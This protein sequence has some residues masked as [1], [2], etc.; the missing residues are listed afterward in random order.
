MTLPASIVRTPALDRWLRFN[1]DGSLTVYTGKAELGQGITTAIAMI[2]A[3]ELDLPLER[4]RVQTADTE[5]TPNELITAGSMSV[6]QSGSA[7]RVASAAARE[8]L[9]E[10]AA[11]VL[12]VPENSLHLEDGVVTSPQTNEQTDYWSLLDGQGFDLDITEAPRLKDPH[13]YR[14]VGR[15]QHR[16]DIPAKVSGDVAFVHDMELPNLR[17]G[18]LV[19][20]P[21]AAAR[22]LDAPEQL[23]DFDGIVVRNG[24]FLGVVAA[25][26]AD[27]VA[28]AEALAQKA[29]WSSPALDPLPEAIPDYLRASVSQSLR[30]IDGTPVED[31]DAAPPPLP[32]AGQSVSASYYRPF[33]M[34]G[35]MGPSAA[36]AQFLNGVLTVFSHSQGVEILKRALMELLNLGA[37]QVHVIH[38]EGAGCYGHNGA[39]DVAFDAA[40]LAMAA[41]PDP[42]KVCW[43]RTEEHGWEPYGPATVVDMRAQL[44]PE[45]RIL[46]WQHEA[47][48]FSHN[49]RPR[50]AA[51][52][53]AARWLDPPVEPP[54]RTPALFA[55]VGIHR[56]M[57]P[58]Y[59]LP[60]TH[61]VKHFVADSPLRTSSL[62]SLGAF[63]NVFAI[64]S[65]MDELAHA[66][67]ADPIGFRLDHLED[68]RARAVLTA[69]AERAPV[70]PAADSAGRGVAIARYKNR[71]T[72][73]AVLV[74]LTVGDDAVVRLD[75]VVIVA[76]A[77]LVV[78][79]DGLVNQLEGGFIQAAS[80]TLKEEVRWDADGV[81]TLDWET[82]PI[83]TFPEIP[84]IET[85]LID[86]PLERSL[87]VGEASTGPTPAAIANAI[88]DAKGVRVR[89]LPFTPDRIRVAAAQ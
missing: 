85:H 65:F 9:L 42:V 21:V 72:W 26:A 22:L 43:T 10:R 54:P 56:N 77:G 6:E 68:P 24:S 84:V 66:A 46:A 11:R 3:E 12:R 78:D 30:V 71:Q 47:Y 8:A 4:I 79:P 19:K 31:A 45:G 57:E 44:S 60:A 48:S 58:L 81:T 38:E 67:G 35:S 74:D 80:W 51:N 61:L 16:V 53:L 25:T 5:L 75:H 49:G 50:S 15:K 59:D 7:V 76:D 32:A 87:G 55:E 70:R 63:A 29:T 18:R 39:D 62:R 34:H 52:L 41:E 20:P 33:Q 73:C 88:F 28:A 83:L 69:L 89:S 23:P 86:R 2:A 36:V 27:A 14:I 37:D 13:A 40:L 17:H 64:E 82:Y 1:A